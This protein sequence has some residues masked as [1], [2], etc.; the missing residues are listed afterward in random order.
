MITIEISTSYFFLHSLIVEAGLFEP[1]RGHQGATIDVAELIGKHLN[2][3]GTN[4]IL[5][6]TIEQLHDV[7]FQENS[8]ILAVIGSFQCSKT[9]AMIMKLQRHVTGEFELR[10]L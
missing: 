2:Q 10:L 8:R 1:K 3:D 6:S 9:E 7:V 4:Y 5:D